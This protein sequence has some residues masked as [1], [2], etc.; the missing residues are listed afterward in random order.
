MNDPFRGLS[1]PCTIGISVA[2][3]KS[4]IARAFEV[5]RDLCTFPPTIVIPKTLIESE[6]TAAHSAIASSVPGSA[7]MTTFTPVC[8]LMAI[9]IR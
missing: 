9:Y 3:M 5:P 1:A 6:R 7:S 4:R 2:S 8:L